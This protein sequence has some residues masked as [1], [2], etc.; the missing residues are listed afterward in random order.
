M[1]AGL[2]EHADA[3]TQAEVEVDRLI[4]ELLKSP[5]ERLIERGR[6][7]AA[8]LAPVRAALRAFWAESTPTAFAEALPYEA[9]RRPLKETRQQLADFLRDIS[10]FS[11]AEQ[12]VFQL[13]R[14]RLRQ[15]ARA[16]WPD[17][18]TSLLK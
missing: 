2:P 13:A 14:D 3:V 11:K 16:A 17:E 1:E 15:N 4:S 8:Q 18:L 10:A 6:E 5:I 7:I 9:S 12:D